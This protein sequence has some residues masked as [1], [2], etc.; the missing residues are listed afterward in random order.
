MSKSLVGRCGG[1]RVILWGRVWARGLDAALVALVLFLIVTCVVGASNEAPFSETWWGRHLF[2]LLLGFV[3][4]PV[5]AAAGLPLLRWLRLPLDILPELEAGPGGRE[6][7]TYSGHRMLSRRAQVALAAVVGVPLLVGL[8]YAEENIRGE[9]GWNH[10]K[11]QQEARGERM[12]PAALVPPPVPDDQN[13]ATTPYLAPLFLNPLAV[14]LNNSLSPRYEAASSRVRPREVARSNIWVLVGGIDLPAWHAAF[15]KGTN[16]AVSEEEAEADRVFRLRYGLPR[17]APGATA[18]EPSSIEHQ[19]ST[20]APTVAEAAAGVLAAL[21][22]AEPVL[23]EL[24]AASRRPYSRFNLR[25]DI[26]NPAEILLPHYSS[27]KRVIQVLQ[28]RASAELAL[29]RTDQAFE[30]IQFMFRLTDTIRHEPLLISYLVRLAIMNITLEPLAE[31]LARHQWS[32]AQLR[33]FEE[34]L[35]QFDFLADGRQALQGERVFFGGLIDY[36]RRSPNKFEVMKRIGLDSGRQGQQ[37]GV[38]WEAAVLAAVPNGWFYLEKVSYNRA[39]QDYLVPAIDVPG[40]RISPDGCGRAAA[41]CNALGATP[42]PARVLRHQFF[43]G[44]LVP[45]MSHT[46][47]KMARAQAGTDCA[48]LACALERYRLARGQFPESLGALVPEFISQVPQDVINGQP[49]NYRRTPDGQY[50]LYSVGWDAT[51]GG[52]VIGRGPNGKSVDHTKGDWVW[53][54]PAA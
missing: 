10:Y 26:D 24:R 1:K 21:A 37:A 19:S 16:A 2:A 28:L 39:F 14:G 53:R 33:A 38:S 3:A 48:A 43:A 45:A 49:L 42:W 30:D 50:V 32:E 11:R 7:E 35:R 27:L 5:L 8:F 13:F 23:E 20:N 41:H 18:A 29:G 25:Y 52:G 6:S 36:V 46:A 22:E 54:L 51:D 4:L 9:R 40:H 47:Q 12:D 31:G 34:R 17:T 44:L 15:L